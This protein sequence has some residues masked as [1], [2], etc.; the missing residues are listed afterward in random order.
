MIEYKDI[1]FECKADP[2]KREFE[3]YAS[4][5][6]NVDRVR[7]VVI[8]GAF[9]QTIEEDFSNG[10]IKTLWQ[11]MDPLGMP[12]HM[13]EDSKGLFVKARVSKTTLGQ[14]ALILM[15][16]GVVD[17]MSIGYQVRE[18]DER[19]DGVRELKNLKLFEFSPVLFP[20]NEEADISGVK[21]LVN[22]VESIESRKELERLLRKSGFSRSAAT[23]LVAKARDLSGLGEPTPDEEEEIESDPDLKEMIDTIKSLGDSARLKV[24]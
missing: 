3:G 15:S 20:A 8:K 5:F 19:E 16:D 11:H 10:R 2:T 6:G 13:E 12:T 1:T 4:T 24:F 14:D 9:E 17:R 21:V 23:T 7:D 18:E 22:T